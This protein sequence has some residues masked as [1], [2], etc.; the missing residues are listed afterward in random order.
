[1]LCCVAGSISTDVSNDLNA[2]MFRAGKLD[3]EEGIT[4]L[5]NV[6]NFVPK[7]TE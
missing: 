7:V 3:S 2:L 5:R 6:A 4:I 1:M